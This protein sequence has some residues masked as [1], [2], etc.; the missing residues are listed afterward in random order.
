MPQ[1]GPFVKASLSDVLTEH[2]VDPYSREF[3]FGSDERCTRLRNQAIFNGPNGPMTLLSAMLRYGL[4][5]TKRANLFFS[6]YHLG[7]SKQIPQARLT[8]ADLANKV[9]KEKHESVPRGER[10]SCA[11]MS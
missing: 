3:I 1:L 9:R 5:D 7:S 4:D 2:K 8:L 11:T 6:P 10:R